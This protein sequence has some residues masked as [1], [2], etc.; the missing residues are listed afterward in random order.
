MR[1]VTRSGGTVAAVVWDSRGGFVAVG[2]THMQSM[3]RALL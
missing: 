2:P 3:W 1:R